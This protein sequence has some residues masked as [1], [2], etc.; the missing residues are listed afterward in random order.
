MAGT[1]SKNDDTAKIRLDKEVF[2]DD[3][4]MQSVTAEIALPAE[5]TATAL[6][7]QHPRELSDE[8]TAVGTVAKYLPKKAGSDVAEL[9]AELAD[10]Q[11]LLD[12]QKRK[13]ITC[14]DAEIAASVE[15]T[16]RLSNQIQKAGANP[17]VALA[18]CEVS[19]KQFGKAESERLARA[20]AAAS[21]AADH[22]DRLEAI[23]EEQVEAW[24]AHLD[25]VRSERASRDAA[26]LARRLLLDQRALEVNAILEEKLTQAKGKAGCAPAELA[27]PTVILQVE[28][29]KAQ[30][31]QLKKDSEASLA[32]AEKK[33][34]ALLDKPASLQTASP[35]TPQQA[36]PRLPEEVYNLC[37]STVM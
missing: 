19:A 2:V 32:A 7:L 12:L 17:A 13:V 23:C 15:K 6:L 10:H 18:A 31:N 25:Q 16:E 28:D 29:A 21:R 36:A 22:A 24:T 14:S 26:W 4:A 30:L 20:D 11:A 27:V 8:W 34:Q 1:I 35:V 3:E 33:K 5:Y 9:E 37:N